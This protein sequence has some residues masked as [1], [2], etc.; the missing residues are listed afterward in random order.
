M[1][2]KYPGNVC[3]H[4]LIERNQD[5]CSFHLFGTKF[6]L[7]LSP[8]HP[9]CFFRF[10][11]NCLYVVAFWFSILLIVFLTC[12]LQKLYS[13]NFVKKNSLSKLTFQPKWIAAQTLYSEIR[14]K[15]DI[16]VLHKKEYFSPRGVLSSSRLNY[17]GKAF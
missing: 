7:I 4:Y 16:S 2:M 12:S 5:F 10:I 1:V 6:F 8:Y 13:H 11:E 3:I 15:I 17:W 9:S 14:C